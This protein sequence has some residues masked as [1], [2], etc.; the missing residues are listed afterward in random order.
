MRKNHELSICPA[1]GTEYHPNPAF[2]GWKRRYCSSDACRKARSR[3][4]TEQE[5]MRRGTRDDVFSVYL[6]ELRE[7]PQRADL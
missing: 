3:M 7:P 2:L 5:P 1:C 6:R 4:E